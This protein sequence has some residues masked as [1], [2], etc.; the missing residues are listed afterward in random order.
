MTLRTPGWIYRFL[1]GIAVCV[2]IAIYQAYH[3][4]M[5][6]IPL[7]DKIGIFAIQF[8]CVAGLIWG[9]LYYYAKHRGVPTKLN[10]RMVYVVLIPPLIVL[11][12][13]SAYLIVPPFLKSISFSDNS[14]PLALVK[15]IVFAAVAIIGIANIFHPRK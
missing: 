3:V 1:I 8:V 11:G 14:L 15:I 9:F 13:I 5:S 4:A 6:G 2:V 10:N 7:W 12:L